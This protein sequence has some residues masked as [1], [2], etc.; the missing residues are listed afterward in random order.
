MQIF[1]GKVQAIAEEGNAQAHGAKNRGKHSDPHTAG[2]GASKAQPMMP[3][4]ALGRSSIKMLSDALSRIWR[5]YGKIW[6]VPKSIQKH[7]P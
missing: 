2:T 5:W 4:D 3:C 7:W 6:E 1:D